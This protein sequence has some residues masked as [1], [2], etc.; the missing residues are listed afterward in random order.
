MKIFSFAVQSEN[1]LNVLFSKES[2]A[3]FLIYKN[4]LYTNFKKCL[5]I[6]K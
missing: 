1:K 4:I 5:K 2:Y 3:D 6:K